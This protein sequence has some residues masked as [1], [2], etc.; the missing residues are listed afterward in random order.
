M[1]GWCKAMWFTL[2]T[3]FFKPYLFEAALS[4]KLTKMLVMTTIFLSLMQM[5]PATVY[6]K[7]VYVWLIF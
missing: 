1:N 5:L 4:V 7:M 6:V 2:A 3:T